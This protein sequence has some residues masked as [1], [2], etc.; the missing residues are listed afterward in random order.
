MARAKSSSQRAGAA[1]TP[2]HVR[3]TSPP[4]SAAAWSSRRSGLVDAID[5][6]ASAGE[7]APAR[8]S[9]VRQSGSSTCSR[10]NTGSSAT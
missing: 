4:N 8:G 3:G 6:T 1:S 2:A 7:A 9:G 10:P 5:S